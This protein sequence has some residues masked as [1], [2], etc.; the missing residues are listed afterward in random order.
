MDV[1]SDLDALIEI[2]YFILLCLYTNGVS[3]GYKLVYWSPYQSDNG[4]FTHKN[5]SDMNMVA[6]DTM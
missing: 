1:R 6:G 3:G 2:S 4:L 5:G